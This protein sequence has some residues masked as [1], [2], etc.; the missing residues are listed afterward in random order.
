MQDLEIGLLLVISLLTS[1]VMLLAILFK[2]KIKLGK[3]NFDTYWIVTLTGALLLILL[4]IINIPY[5]INGLTTDTSIN[6]LKILVLFLSMTFIS[7]ILDE[8][9]FFRYIAHI[10]LK[11]A[12]K[13][14]IKIFLYLY[15]IVSILTIFTSNDVIILTFTPFI[16]YFAK[17]A[18]INP[19]PYLVAEFVAANTWSMALIIGNPTNIYLATTY[20]INFIDYLSVMILPTLV[21]SSVAFIVLYLLFR[22]YLKQ[23]INPVFEKVVL[24][25]KPAL[26]LGLVH[27]FLCT[28]ILAVSAYMEI[29]MWIVALFF[30]LSLLISTT[31][32]YCINRNYPHEVIQSLKRVPWQF[33]PFIISMFIIVLAL[34]S[35]QVTEIIANFLNN[36]YPIISYGISSFLAANIINNIPMSVLFSYVLGYCHPG[37]L[38]SAVYAVIIGSNIGAFLTP[39]GA[40]AGI[41]WMNVVKST[42]IKYSFIQFVK[43]GVITSVPTLLTAL[44]MLSFTVSL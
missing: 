28:I 18:N 37:N 17:Y 29:E 20:G 14:Q 4:G 1:L 40:L 43:Y 35:Y 9:S 3:L 33:I 12:G 5:I 31:C 21:S 6:P 23:S 13:S 2:P 19:I 8:L 7:L 16:C 22:K 42:G 27:L 34:E 44:F 15:I 11:L 32:L 25:N 10:T 41:M 39:F 24:P 30:S 26:A 36:S 38:L